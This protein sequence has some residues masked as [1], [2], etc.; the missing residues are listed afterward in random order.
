MQSPQTRIVAQPVHALVRLA[1]SCQSA[2]GD[3][4]SEGNTSLQA[5]PQFVRKDSGEKQQHTLY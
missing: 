2:N 4:E 5:V 3:S 1:R